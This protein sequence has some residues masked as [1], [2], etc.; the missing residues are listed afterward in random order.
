VTRNKEEAS[1]VIVYEELASAIFDEINNVLAAGK[2]LSPGGEFVFDESIYHRIYAERQHVVDGNE[3]EHLATIAVT[4]FYA[5]MMF[6]AT[7]LPPQVVAKLLQLFPFT[8]KSPHVRMLCRLALLLGDEVLDW[9]GSKLETAWRNH[10]QPPGHLFLVRELRASQADDRRL[11]ALQLGER[12]SIQ[13]PG[14]NSAVLVKDL[15]ERRQDAAAFL[16]RSCMQV[17]KGDVG[18]RAG[19]RQF[20]V[21]AYGSELAVRGAAVANLLPRR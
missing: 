8:S 17:F 9:F 2:L 13:V 20:D 5:P 21:L 19:A 4:K 11:T 7:K 10:P 14:E 16:S 6:W 3:H 1:G 18:W 12:A 15:L